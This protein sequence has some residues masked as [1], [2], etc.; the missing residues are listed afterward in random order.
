MGDPSSQVALANELFTPS[1]KEVEKAKRALAA[2]AQAQK[3]GKGAWRWTA[4]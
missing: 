1:T 3:E 2:M 4:A